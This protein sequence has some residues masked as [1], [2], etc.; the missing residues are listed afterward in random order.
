MNSNE[1]CAVTNR[2]SGVVVYNLPER[3]IRREFMPRET[4]KVP[5]YEIEE[6]ISQP[7]G[8]TLF[9][10]YLMVDTNVMKDALNIEPEPEYH[11]T[12][13]MIDS[14][15][16][17][18]TLDEFKDALDFAPDGVKDLIKTHAVSLPLNDLTKCEAIQKQLG[19]NVLQAIK[20][21]KDT[22]ADDEV[23]EQATERRV[24]ATTN[25]QTG[26]RT[27]PKYNIVKTEG[28]KKEV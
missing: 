17:T 2:S 5:Y 11:F 21:E 8:R 27:I 28:D 1:I 6:V 24:A 26:R 13:D 7:G 23:K 4:K 19:F 18:C 15:M 10:H 20:N 9:Y 3:H 12:E 22:V 25:E 14:W 16:N